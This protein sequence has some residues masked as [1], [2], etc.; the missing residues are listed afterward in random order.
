LICMICG[1]GPRTSMAVASEI[2]MKR[3]SDT[4]DA[5]RTIRRDMDDI[6]IALD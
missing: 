6:A 1:V 2:A 3:R 4:D 5:T